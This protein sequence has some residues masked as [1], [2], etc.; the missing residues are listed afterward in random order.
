MSVLEISIENYSEKTEEIPKESEEERQK[1]LI[2]ESLIV[3]PH[4]QI[5]ILPG[6]IADVVIKYSPSARMTPFTEKVNMHNIYHRTQNYIYFFLLDFLSSA[7]PSR[8]F[9]HS[10]SKLH[11]CG[12]CFRQGFYKLWKCC[13]WLF[14]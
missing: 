3:T 4:K 8:T 2:H 5:K 1:R 6:Q 9:M 7:R 10:K 13:F 12:V 11:G 14:L